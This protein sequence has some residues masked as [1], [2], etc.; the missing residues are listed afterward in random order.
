MF[1][2][3]ESLR[4]AVPVQRQRRMAAVPV[5]PAGARCR[6]ARRAP[7]AHSGRWRHQ[8][9]RGLP[10]RRGRR[11]R[12]VKRRPAQ[13]QRVQRFGEQLAV[14]E[15][16]TDEVRRVLAALVTRPCPERFGVAGGTPSR[17]CRSPTRPG[18]TTAPGSAAAAAP[19]A[20]PG[21][22]AT[23]VQQQDATAESHQQCRS[24]GRPKQTATGHP[25]RPRRPPV[26]PHDTRPGSPPAPRANRDRPAALPASSITSVR[27]H[28]VPR[29]HHPCRGQT[30]YRRQRQVPRRS[31]RRGSRCLRRPRVGKFQCGKICRRLRGRTRGASD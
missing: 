11:R 19:S 24:S 21:P 12:H 30:I 14:A 17:P 29:R 25:R 28:S 10:R 16:V 5:G 15:L 7:A 27:N 22:T 20:R 1:K 2:A 4:L 8:A 31:R 9:A 6:N 18:H 23:V 13:T 26:S 3:A